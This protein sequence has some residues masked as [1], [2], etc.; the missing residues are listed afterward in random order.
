MLAR[1]PRRVHVHLNNSTP[2][3]SILPEERK[4]EIVPRA[5]ARVRACP[6]FRGRTRASGAVTLS[7]DLAIT[8]GINLTNQA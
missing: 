4:K 1:V 6:A 7:N 2:S 5:L 8:G 3:F